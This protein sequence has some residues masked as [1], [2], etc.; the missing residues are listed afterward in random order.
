VTADLV[1]LRLRVIV[2]RE[3]LDRQLAEGADQHTNPALGLRA[4]Q[5]CTARTRRVIA[6]RL[7]RSLRAARKASSLRWGFRPLARDQLLAESDAL[8][9]L[10][11]RLEAPRQVEPMGVAL[12][13]LLVTDPVSPLYVRSDPGTL[14]TVVRLATAAMGAPV[15]RTDSA[16]R[17]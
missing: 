6:H 16:S 14:Y 2:R 12:A 13:R 15:H 5:L 10:A 11:W 8:M 4:A 17:S 3:G 1:T 7:R 9:D